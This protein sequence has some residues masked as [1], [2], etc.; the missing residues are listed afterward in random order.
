MF[1]PS[2]F[3]VESLEQELA[4]ADFAV[5]VLAP[6]D[7]V[8]SRE[9]TI[10]APRDNVIFELGLFMGVLGRSRTFLV[11]P[12]GL[13]LKIP[14]DLLAITTLAYDVGDESEPAVAVAS[15]CNEIRG[16][17]ERGGPR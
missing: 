11:C 13:D 10:D 12:R 1:R 3:P 9:T 14:T 2:N 16:L 4:S 8:V 7:T 6:D 17:I 5:M 15:A